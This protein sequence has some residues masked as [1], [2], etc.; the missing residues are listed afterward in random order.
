M[1]ADCFFSIGSTHR[2]CQDYALANSQVPYAI[3]CDGCSGAPHTDV[4][5]RLLAVSAAQ[6]I[7]R[8]NYLGGDIFNSVL[9]QVY[10]IGRAMELPI[11]AL[12]STIITLSVEDGCFCIRGVGDGAIIAKVKDSQS[13]YLLEVRFPSGAPYYL[14]YELSSRDRMNYRTAFSNEIQFVSYDNDGNE[15]VDTREIST[16]SWERSLSLE[17]YD[18]CAIASDGIRSFVSREV[19][20]TGIRNQPILPMEI[21]KEVMDFKG[22]QGEFVQRRC[23][24]ALARFAERGW[25]YTDDFSLAVIAP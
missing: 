15:L 11:D 17:F 21:V 22:Y 25:S 20:E 18:L 3:V 24:K 16:P 14:R 10:T 8:G 4:G 6:H 19:T 7:R 5:A 23:R 9:S 1:N 12:S 13:I 2:V